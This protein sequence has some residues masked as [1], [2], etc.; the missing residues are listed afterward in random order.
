MGAYPG[1]RGALWLQ[2]SS[3]VVVAQSPA[4]CC[5][6]W[7]ESVGEKTFTSSKALNRAVAARSSGI[8]AT[9]DGIFFIISPVNHWASRRADVVCAKGS[10]SRSLG[11]PMRVA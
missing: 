6:D 1:L 4:V 7:G 2:F 11:I 3:A 5:H 8:Q 9:V 10:I